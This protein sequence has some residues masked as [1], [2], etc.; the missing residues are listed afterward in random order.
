MTVVLT[1]AF[2]KANDFEKIIAEEGPKKSE[3]YYQ[4]KWASENYPESKV[5]YILEDKTRVDILTEEYA[6]EVDFAY[7]YTEAIGQSL[8]YSI[9]TKRK[10][11]I[12]LVLKSDKDLKYLQR[13]MR[14]IVEK[15]L[16][17]RVWIHKEAT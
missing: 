3:R 13:L 9:L 2:V 17:I 10:A 5:E 7:K 8:Y 4:Y 15:K 16:D 12:L 11:G 6:I 14:I 1:I